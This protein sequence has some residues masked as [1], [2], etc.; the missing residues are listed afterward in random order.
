MLCYVLDVLFLIVFCF[1][2]VHGSICSSIS[3]EDFCT[4]KWHTFECHVLHLKFERCFSRMMKETIIE[5]GL[6]ITVFTNLTETFYSNCEHSS[7]SFPRLAD[8]IIVCDNWIFGHKNVKTPF[9]LAPFAA[10]SEGRLLFIW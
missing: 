1:V 3:L 6:I 2:V 9:S 7:N 8:S 10:I 5:I 4:T